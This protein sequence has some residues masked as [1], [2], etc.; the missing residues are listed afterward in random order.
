M[1]FTCKFLSGFLLLT[2]KLIDVYPWLI[3][4]GVSRCANFTSAVRVSGVSVGAKGLIDSVATI[5]SPGRCWLSSTLHKSLGLS[6][7]FV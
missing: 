6:Y 2:L 7:N 1:S 3:P 4:P 5:T